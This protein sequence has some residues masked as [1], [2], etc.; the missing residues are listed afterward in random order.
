LPRVFFIR[1]RDLSW[2][3]YYACDEVFEDVSSHKEKEFSWLQ[4]AIPT[5][6]TACN[7]DILE[8]VVEALRL[9]LSNQ[10]DVAALK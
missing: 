3:N 10:A 1:H 2:R 5:G 7:H 9:S 4:I 6:C 8:Q